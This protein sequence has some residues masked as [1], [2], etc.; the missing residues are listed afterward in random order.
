MATQ[1]VNPQNI[2]TSPASIANAL[3]PTWNI[4][5]TQNRCLI[6]DPP[7]VSVP[8]SNNFISL[9]PIQ[10]D[11]QWDRILVDINVNAAASLPAGGLQVQIR[12]MVTDTANWVTVWSWTA[13]QTLGGTGQ[14]SSTPPLYIYAPG[15]TGLV[16]PASSDTWFDLDVRGWWGVDFQVSATSGFS[17]I[18]QLFASTKH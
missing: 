14:P 6:Y 3:T 9:G 8:S 2:S 18:A 13:L 5:S 1:N 12:G 11:A 15:Q 17:A 16:L 4:I 10:L 7:A